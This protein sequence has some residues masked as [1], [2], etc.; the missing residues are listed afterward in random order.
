MNFRNCKI[1]LFFY[2]L[3]KD[4][5]FLFQFLLES[6][7]STTCNKIIPLQCKTEV[8]ALKMLLHQVYLYSY[9]LSGRPIPRKCLTGQ[10]CLGLFLCV[11]YM[12]HTQ[13]CLL[14]H[15]TSVDAISTINH[16]YKSIMEK[17]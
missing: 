13:L 12:L 14:F 15:K 6:Q 3:E 4:F 17:Y 1:K 8:R 9:D 7:D 2:C 16:T 5:F 10:V 11:L